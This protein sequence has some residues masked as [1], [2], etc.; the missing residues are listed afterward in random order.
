MQDSILRIYLTTSCSAM[1]MYTAKPLTF[2]GKYIMFFIG[3]KH[4]LPLIL[5]QPKL[6]IL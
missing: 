5:G 1:V 6:Y 4:W 2:S 3:C